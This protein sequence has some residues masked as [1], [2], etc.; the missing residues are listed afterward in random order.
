MDQPERP[1]NDDH[2]A[3]KDD[4]FN[5]FPQEGGRPD[6]EESGSDSFT[7]AEEEV[8]DG[9]EAS[10]MPQ[11]THHYNLSARPF[12]DLLQDEV[13][14]EDAGPSTEPPKRKRWYSYRP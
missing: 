3:Q 8:A 11:G 12:T 1:E 6:P 7:T 10:T 4:Q 9:A 5:C 13:E 14:Q 2:N